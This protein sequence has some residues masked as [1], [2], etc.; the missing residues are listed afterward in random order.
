MLHPAEPPLVG[1]LV[2]PGG[3]PYP[4]AKILA[5]SA[6]ASQDRHAAPV[7][8][9]GGFVLDRLGS[10]DYELRAVQDGV[11][12]VRV[13]GAR[14]G[15]QVELVGTA[16]HDGPAVEVTVIDAEGHTVEG[17]RV[18]GGPFRDA[19]TDH[20]GRVRVES[21]LRGSVV[22]HLRARSGTRRGEAKVMIPHQDTPVAVELRLED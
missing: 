4:R 11:E 22:L 15:T 8:E 18:D 14:A 1:T 3:A 9:R 10:A 20:A 7:D 17:A 5:A 6:Q 19:R 13:A 21:T 12:L 16:R 2:D